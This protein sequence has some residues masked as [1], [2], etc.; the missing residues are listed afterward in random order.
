MPNTLCT[1]S[2]EGVP[3][4]AN[5]PLTCIQH[6]PKP[7][8]SACNCINA[9]AID[10]SSTQGSDKVGSAATTIANEA[11]AIGP[12]PA[13]L[14]SLNRCNVSLSSTTTNCHG[15]LLLDVGAN[16]AASYINL[17]ASGSIDSEV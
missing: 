17:T 10:A 4:A 11:F 6:D 5:R 12:A 1:C 9:A 7:K 14:H 16:N 2:S 8:S 3:S 15:R 13:G